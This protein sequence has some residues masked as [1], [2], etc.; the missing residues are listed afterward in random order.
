MQK[1]T[2]CRRSS[3]LKP[4][5]TPYVSS[6]LSASSTTLWVKD[7]MCNIA[8]LSWNPSWSGRQSARVNSLLCNLRYITLM[9]S[10]QA[11]SSGKIRSA[12]RL[13]WLNGFVIS[14]CSYHCK[15]VTAKLSLTDKCSFGW[16]RSCGFI[17]PQ[18]P[19]F[20]QLSLSLSLKTSI[21]EGVMYCLPI[22]Q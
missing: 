8:H 12:F 16:A 5:Q 9:N 13:H 18:L 6:R 14:I 3:I 21:K 7:W 11:K 10:S 1:A 22:C 2:A 4:A 20:D 19:S 17:L 15:Y